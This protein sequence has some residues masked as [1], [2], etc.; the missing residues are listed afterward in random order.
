MTH[1]FR[2]RLGFSQGVAMPEKLLE[3]L[4]S[5]ISGGLE[6]V[7]ATEEEDRQG[8]DYWVRRDHGL[9]IVSVDVKHRDFDPVLKY[10]SDDALIETT[11]VYRGPKNGPWLDCHREKPGWTLDTIKRTDLIVYTWPQPDG[12]RRFW[13]LY[14]P[15]LYEAARRNWREWA[16]EYGERSAGNAGYLTLFICPPRRVIEEAIKA[17][18]AGIT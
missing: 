11:S 18:T 9:P 16:K 14:F 13:I 4:L 1:D 12:K 8:T 5:S 10:G 6:I 7:P 15:F 3:Y 2:E 17:L